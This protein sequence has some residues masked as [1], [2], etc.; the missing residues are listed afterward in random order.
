MSI[1][2]DAAR[3]LTAETLAD[4]WFTYDTFVADMHRGRGGSLYGSHAADLARAVVLRSRVED[5]VAA[6]A[7][8]SS[9]ARIEEVRDVLE[10]YVESVAQ[11][12]ARIETLETAL[13]DI[14]RMAR[15]GSSYQLGTRVADVAAAALA[16]AVPAPPRESYFPSERLWEA[17]EAAE[18]ARDAEGGRS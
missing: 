1:E 16:A 10:G 11:A 7:R 13:R 8:A 15:E 3:L 17:A 4:A 18:A 2:Q 14:A 9:R 5:A 6:R 12:N